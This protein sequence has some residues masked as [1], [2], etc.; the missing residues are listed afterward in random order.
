M[1]ELSA[2]GN[3]GVS[4]PLAGLRDYIIEDNSQYT[5]FKLPEG[6]KFI[7]SIEILQ[8]NYN[9]MKYGINPINGTTTIITCFK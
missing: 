8:R 2:Q 9:R 4:D 5:K 7:P 1:K 6:T 3:K